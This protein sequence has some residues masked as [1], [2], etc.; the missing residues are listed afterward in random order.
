MA[1]RTFPELPL[2]VLPLPTPSELVIPRR[3][4]VPIF[5][6]LGISIHDVVNDADKKWKVRCFYRIT[7]RIDNETWLRRRADELAYDAWFEAHI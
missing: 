2:P 4:L 5:E 6:F 3:P 7:S 1:D